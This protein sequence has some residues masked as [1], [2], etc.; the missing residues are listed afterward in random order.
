ML[1]NTITTVER[2]LFSFLWNKKK[3][4]VKRE[5]LYQNY[6]KGCIRMTDVGLMLKTKRLA[7]GLIHR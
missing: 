1:K 3:D 4:K 6:D 5:G 2:K 7:A